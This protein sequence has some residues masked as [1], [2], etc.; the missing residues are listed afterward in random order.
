MRNRKAASNLKIRPI[1]ETDNRQLISLARS[2][3]V[4]A[5]VKLGVD[6]APIFWA[7]SEMQSKTWDILVAEDG[8]EI[9]GFIDLSHRKFRLSKVVKQVTYV[10][11]TG[12]H[13]GWRG[14]EVFP[15]LLRASERLARKRGSECAIA[16]VNVNNMRFNKLLRFIY[17]DSIC[18]ENLRVS[19]VLLGPRYRR[20]KN[21]R[22]ERATQ[23]DMQM[24]MDLMMRY[25][26]RYQLA[27]I[28]DRKHFTDLFNSQLLDLL[29]VRDDKKKIVAT[30]GLWDQSHMRRIIVL[31]YAPPMLWIKRLINGSRYFTRIARVPDPGSHFEYFYSV[32]AA[33][34]EGFENSFCEILRFVCNKYADRNYNFLILAIPESSKVMKTCS[35]LW[36]IS[37]NNVPVVIPLTN[38]MVTFLK[39]IG[40][41]SLYL[42]YALS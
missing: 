17:K 40:S 36:I 24:I 34:E 12:V 20:N 8:N 18:C 37:N 15:R 33:F 31:D 14:S 29:V 5:R 11:L 19:C 38:D 6:R 25:Y 39:E 27:P 2:I 28:L 41:C 23:E 7:F 10:G 1:K 16:L 30:M 32:F 22:V 35:D 13:T 3:G 21:V 26:C 4:P 9:V 42:E